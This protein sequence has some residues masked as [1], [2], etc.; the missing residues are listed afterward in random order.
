MLDSKGLGRVDRLT[1]RNMVFRGRHGVLPAEQEVA[2]LFEVDVD[3]FLNLQAAGETDD[4]GRALDYRRVYEL[5]R[6]QVEER[7]FHLVEALA[8]AIARALRNELGA[9]GLEKLT[10]RVRKPQVPLPGVLDHVEVEINRPVEKEA[11]Q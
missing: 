6:E 8:E 9:T 10:V 2:H 1:L 3:L 5:V 4:L 11:R 7:R